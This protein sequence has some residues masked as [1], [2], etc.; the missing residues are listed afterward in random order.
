MSNQLNF[1]N[2]QLLTEYSDWYNACISCL[3]KEQWILEFHYMELNERNTDK[4]LYRNN[5]RWKTNLLLYNIIKLASFKILLIAHSLNSCEDQ[6]NWKGILSLPSAI[7]DQHSI[8]SQH[9]MSASKLKEL[10][11]T[12][13]NF[14]FLLKWELLIFIS[15]SC[16]CITSYVS[17]KTIFE[18]STEDKCIYQC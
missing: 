10:T 3:F 1:L 12:M 14:L 17:I 16:P 2:C 18:N 5:K 9:K 4:I 15:L 11:F 13:W 7:P 8:P 6:K